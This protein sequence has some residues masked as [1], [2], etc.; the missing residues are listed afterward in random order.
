MSG[1]RRS[2]RLRGHD[3]RK[4][5]SY[6]VTIVTHD[7][8]QLFGR[9]EKGVMRLSPAGIIARDTWLR[10]PIL[11]PWITLDEWVVMPDHMHGIL[12]FGEAPLLPGY[13]STG[14]IKD[15]QRP[16]GASSGS[17]GAIIAQY[18]GTSAGRINKLRGSP[19]SKLWHRDYH[20]HIIRH[21]AA[22]E[23]IRRYIRLNP[24]KWETSRKH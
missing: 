2:I 6:F 14:R 16:S 7:H 5:A 9:I 17:L 10:I 15:N 12:H 19:G 18:K 13:Q 22:L 21:Q 1:H 8:A 3:Y 23:R 11:T 20:E 4:P 24:L